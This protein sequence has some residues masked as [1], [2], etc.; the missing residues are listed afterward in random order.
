[1]YDAAA[2]ARR[3]LPQ[4]RVAM[5]RLRWWLVSGAGIP[6]APRISAKH[7]STH[8]TAQRAWRW[9]AKF[10]VAGHCTAAAISRKPPNTASCSLRCS[11]SSMFPGSGA[12][13]RNS[14]ISD[15]CRPFA[16]PTTS[17]SQS[18]CALPARSR[19]GKGSPTIHGH[20]LGVNCWGT[21]GHLL[22]AAHPDRP[23]GH[24][25]AAS[26]PAGGV[27]GQRLGLPAVPRLWRR[28]RDVC[29]VHRS[30]APDR[31]PTAPGRR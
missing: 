7:S 21:P 28:G 1:M 24:G 14:S 27:P 19:C 25:A 6:G 20:Q 11:A 23:P 22:G 5:N 15:P 2:A 13:S 8:P 9:P 26:R 18:G 31:W 17:C 10:I 30:G 4:R 12:T 3:L 29:L 16:L